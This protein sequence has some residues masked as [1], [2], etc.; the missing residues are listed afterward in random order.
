MPQLPLPSS[1]S[2]RRTRHLWNLYLEAADLAKGM[3]SKH[4]QHS[5][6]CNT[7]IIYNYTYIYIHISLFLY[8]DRHSDIDMCEYV[9]YIGIYVIYQDLKMSMD[10]LKKCMWIKNGYRIHGYSMSL[11]YIYIYIGYIHQDLHG[12][13]TP[14][15]NIFQLYPQLKPSSPISIRRHRASSAEHQHR[16]VGEE[17]PSIRILTGP[18]WFWVRIQVSQ[19]V[20]VE[21]EAVQLPI[22]FLGHSHRAHRSPHHP[23]AGPDVPS[24]D[25]PGTG[26]CWLLRGA[27]RRQVWIIFPEMESSC[28]LFRNSQLFEKMPW[29]SPRFSCAKTTHPTEQLRQSSPRQ[30]PKRSSH[31]FSWTSSCENGRPPPKIYQYVICIRKIHVHYIQVGHFNSAHKTMFRRL[32]PYKPQ[33]RIQIPNTLRKH[34]LMYVAKQLVNLTSFLTTLLWP[35]VGRDH[36]SPCYPAAAPQHNSVVR[37]QPRIFRSCRVRA[38]LW[39]NDPRRMV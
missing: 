38:R 8:R 32:S 11:E 19:V 29:K 17:E 26:S 4:G 37:S 9:I 16:L 20:P 2:S 7:H 3:D 10:V 23:I 12:K 34:Q 22:S 13:R 33:G 25:H 35:S 39:P 28:S 15:Y 18:G 30:R 21:P 27:T 24:F 1:C 36:G 14:I 5:F 6:G 31:T